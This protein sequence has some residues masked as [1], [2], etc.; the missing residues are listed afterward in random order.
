MSFIKSATTALIAAG[1]LAGLASAAQAHPR[2]WDHQHNSYGGYNSYN[3]GGY[4]N[5]GNNYG[6]QPY[7]RQA[8]VVSAE[9]VY[10]YRRRHGRP[11]QVCH[12]EQ[13]PIYGNTG[14]TY[15]SHGADPGGAIVGALVGGFIGNQVTN[16]DE[17]GTVIGALGG[18]LV[19]SQIGQG[20]YVQHQQGIVGYESRQVCK[21]VHK[22]NK[23]RILKGYNVTYRY[24]GTLYATFTTYH[25]GDYIT[26]QVRR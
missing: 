13:V 1:M 3:S 22:R 10:E 9:P 15:Y 8:R 16:H 20:G 17:A 7:T 11:E 25:P 5:Y 2:N 26:I 21:P 19:G 12:I 24:H 23:K 4:N 14:S 18:A 6:G